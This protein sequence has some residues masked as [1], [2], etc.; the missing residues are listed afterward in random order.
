MQ[1]SFTVEITW[2]LNV[3]EGD[4]KQ[5]DDYRK[6]EGNLEEASIDDAMM[7]GLDKENHDKNSTK[8]SK[9]MQCAEGA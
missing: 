4:P 8:Q 5:R 2:S 9:K 7:K 6:L 1:R 3:K